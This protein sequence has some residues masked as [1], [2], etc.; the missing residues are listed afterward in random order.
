VGKQTCVALRI[1]ESLVKL[2]VVV[3]DEVF[4]ILV[5]VGG[6]GGW[7]SD[8]FLPL[9]SRGG[10]VP[11]AGARAQAWGQALGGGGVQGL[12]HDVTGPLWVIG[13]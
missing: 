10:G 12:S 1:T 2:C 11:R 6:G 7:C 3:E 4:K 9:S 13:G 5:G 8:L